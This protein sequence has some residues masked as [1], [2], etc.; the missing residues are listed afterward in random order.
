VEAPVQDYWES[1]GTVPFEGEEAIVDEAPEII[2]V[3]LPSEGLAWGKKAPSPAFISKVLEIADEVGTNPSWLMTQ[4]YGESRFKAQANL[5]AGKSSDDPARIG[6][7][8]I[9]G[10]LF[11]LM[12]QWA[13]P[14]LG[15][16]FYDFMKMTDLEQ[17]EYAR[18]FYGGA[19]GKLKSMDD[20]FTYTFWPAALRKPS[21]YVLMREGDGIYEQ[22]KQMD[23]RKVGYITKGD[24]ASLRYKMYQD[25]MSNSNRLD[26][27]P[28]EAVKGLVALRRP[29]GLPTLRGTVVAPR[30]QWVA[31]SK[32]E[33][34]GTVDHLDSKL[35]PRF[36]A[37]IQKDLTLQAL[38]QFMCS[39]LES[40]SKKYGLSEG[41]ETLLNGLEELRWTPEKIEASQI[42]EKKQLRRMEGHKKEYYVALL[43]LKDDLEH[44]ASNHSTPENEM[45]IL[46]I[47]E[48]IHMQEATGASKI[49]AV[50]FEVPYVNETIEDW[51]VESAEAFDMDEDELDRPELG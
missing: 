48:L 49:V 40:D 46:A 13:K 43:K 50:G 45:N 44:R 12:K 10:G 33:G 34:V 47:D 32:I 3:A 42:N 11:G 29:T 35:K 1:D 19:K 5:T 2:G 31:L 16:D 25:G 4:F 18:K 24:A 36:L 15:V 39:A 28:T 20:V 22:N 7:K 9:G 21:S 6:K 14:A 8:T 38:L 27:M 17:L 37:V 26:V 30:G 23:V 51:L 41:E